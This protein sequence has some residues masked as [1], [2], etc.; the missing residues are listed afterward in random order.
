MTSVLLLA[1]GVLVVLWRPCR[2]GG[3]RAPRSAIA[4]LL[5]ATTAV[6]AGSLGVV[7]GVVSG[8]FGGALAACGALWHQ[9]VSGQLAWR[10]ITLLAAWVAA[11]PAPGLWALTSGGNRSRRLLRKLRVAG[12]VSPADVAAP[13]RTFVVPGLSTPAVTLGVLAPLILVDDDFWRAATPLQ[14]RVVLA[15]E[16]GH[17]RGRHVV[18]DGAAR[19]LTAGLAPLPGFRQ[20][21]DCV[22]R[23]L[24]ALAD[25]AA[26]RRLDSQ[27]V[28]VEVGR[29]ALAAAPAVGLGTSGFALWRVERLLQPMPGNPRVGMPALLLPFTGLLVTGTMIALADSAQALGSAVH[30][31]FCPV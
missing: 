31:Q 11:L 24:E 6:W 10:E 25:D 22:R 2:W 30:V 21:Y 19:A 29:I 5:T 1:A 27:T 8:E 13:R 15:H 12:L 3:G 7:I 26:V 17:R 9:L 23:Q 4:M 18:V 28:G 20:A 14:R 16:D